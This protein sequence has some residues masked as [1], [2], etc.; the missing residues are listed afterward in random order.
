MDLCLLFDARPYPG[1][2]FLRREVIFGD[3]DLLS[4][5]QYAFSATEYA[6]KL[7]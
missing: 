3:M 1:E 5:Q 2:E 4:L 6:V 7:D